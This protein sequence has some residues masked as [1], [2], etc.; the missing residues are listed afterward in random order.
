MLLLWYYLFAYDYFGFAFKMMCARKDQGFMVLQNSFPHC[1][2]SREKCFKFLLFASCF[3]FLSLIWFFFPCIFKG[4]QFVL[5]RQ[6]LFAS[7]LEC[8]DWMHL[9][10][11]LDLT[12]WWGNGRYTASDFTVQWNPNFKVQFYSLIY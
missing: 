10:V 12:L 6:H 7:S 9:H 8:F 2:W 4:N 1:K 11:N 5:F 3:L